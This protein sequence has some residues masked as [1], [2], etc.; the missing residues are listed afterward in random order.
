M[1]LT[2]AFLTSPWRT[3]RYVARTRRE[4]RGVRRALASSDAVVISYGH[5]KT[6]TTSATDALSSVAGVTSYHAHVLRPQHFTWVRNTFIAPTEAGICPEDGPAQWALAEALAGDR[7][8]HLVTL[9]RDPVAVQIS[10]F[11][12][13]LQRW[14]RSSKPVDIADIPFEDLLR[15]F[16]GSYP[17]EGVLNWFEHEW[18]QVTGHEVEQ[19]REVR[20]GGCAVVSFGPHRAAVMASDL[21]DEV[22]A[23]HLES[24]LSL[25]AGSVTFPRSN[26]GSDRRR[27]EVYERLKAAISSDS[28]L[29]D[30][31]YASTFARTFFTPETLEGFRRRWSG[32]SS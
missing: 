7:P 29:L 16:H 15:L 32:G 19:L 10:W 21:P 25:P 4:A 23:R 30:R 14:L 11:F 8:V 5:P 17:R 20:D 24:F 22:K 31:V 9:V 3:T 1:T 27:P 28:E 6:A 18:C 13:G 2:Q 26:L 12:F